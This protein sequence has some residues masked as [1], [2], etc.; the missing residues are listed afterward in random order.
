MT[1]PHIDVKDQNYQYAVALGDF[2]GGSGQFCVESNNGQNVNVVDT[3]NRIARVDGRHVHCVRTG[4]NGDR[5]S[6][7]FYDTSDRKKS[8]ASDLNLETTK[9]AACEKG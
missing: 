2:S 7:I 3:R 9:D 4:D 1:S 6:L 5:Y 8:L